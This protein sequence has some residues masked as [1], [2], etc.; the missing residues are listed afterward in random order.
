M[1]DHAEYVLQ[2]WMHCNE[3]YETCQKNINNNKAIPKGA[4]GKRQRHIT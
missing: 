3:E 4:F 1:A 2:N